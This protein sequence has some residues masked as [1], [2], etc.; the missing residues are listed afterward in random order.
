[1]WFFLFF[2]LKGFSLLHA[3]IWKKSIFKPDGNPLRGR[4]ALLNYHIHLWS[5][6]WGDWR[7]AVGDYR[8]NSE[9]ATC[10]APFPARWEGTRGR[11]YILTRV[12]TEI[13]LLFQWSLPSQFRLPPPRATEGSG[14][15]QLHLLQLN[16]SPGRPRQ[17]ASVNDNA[18]FPPGPCVTQPI[19][20]QIPSGHPADFLSHC[21]CILSLPLNK[22]LIRLF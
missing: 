7:E 13:L 10:R 19:C 21:Y 20:T 11:A 12:G 6:Y 22:N 9:D 1:M 14:S 18:L 3:S 8:G 5:D 15:R 2:P 4:S 17:P 16:P